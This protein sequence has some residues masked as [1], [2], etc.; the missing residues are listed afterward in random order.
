[1]NAIKSFVTRFYPEDNK[2][3]D[4][5]ENCIENDHFECLKRKI[6]RKKL[7]Y[8]LRLFFKMIYN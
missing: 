1:M 4:T 5:I 6:G 7:K 8:P 2:C 3:C